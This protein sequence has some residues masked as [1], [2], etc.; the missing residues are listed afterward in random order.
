MK[1]IL[2]DGVCNFCNFWVKFAGKRDSKKQLRFTPMQSDK[3]QVLLN[4]YHIQT[5]DLSTVILIDEDKVCLQSDAALRI[6]KYL[7][8]GWKFFYVLHFIPQSIRNFIY[9]WI[10]KNRYRWFGKSEVCM[11]PNEELKGRFL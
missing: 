6:C 3:G 9:T 5:K 10:A 1:I 7:D 2:F 11:L 4:E 8:G